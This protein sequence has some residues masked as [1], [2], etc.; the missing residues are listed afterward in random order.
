MIDRKTKTIDASVELIEDR[1]K[2]SKLYFSMFFIIGWI[3]ACI[4]IFVLPYK[5]SLIG[6]G[7]CMLIFSLYYLQFQF[8]ECTML[9]LKKKGEDKHE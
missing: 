7:I 2:Q 1:L 9:Y 4:G 8:F 6:F 5:V 3:A